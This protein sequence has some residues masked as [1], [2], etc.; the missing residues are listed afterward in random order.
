MRAIGTQN[1][2]SFECAD[3]PLGL[4]AAGALL[5]YVKYTQRGA[6]PHI[7]SLKVERRHQGVLLDAASQRNLELVQNLAGGKEFTLA[8]VIDN[9]I[10]P[11]GSRLLRRWLLRPIR[12]RQIL[13]ERQG[14]IATLIQDH[15]F[16]RLQPLFDTV[17]DIERIR[18]RIALRSARPRDLLTLRSTLGV[19][20]SLKQSLTPL[21]HPKIQEFSVH[22]GDY[23]ALHE[24][25]LRAIVF[26]I[27][28]S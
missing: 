1:L 12:D 17:G 5:Q 24:Q 9:T 27:P 28:L 4:C 21:G 19:L 15:H 2:S 7:R 23:P 10:T 25:L 18:A 8:S 16:T 14:A 20:P 11:M 13:S 22:L 26:L 3:H 6:L